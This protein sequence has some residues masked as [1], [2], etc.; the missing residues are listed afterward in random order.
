MYCA[1]NRSGMTMNELELQNNKNA[2]WGEGKI[3][4]CIASDLKYTTQLLACGRE[5][6]RDLS[7]LNRSA[8]GRRNIINDG[9]EWF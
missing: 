2:I 9:N 3:F 6:S 4:A 1:G 7:I 5:K 8:Q